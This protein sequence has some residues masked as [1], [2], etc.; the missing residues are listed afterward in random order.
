MRRLSLRTVAELGAITALALSC[1]SPASRG[2]QAPAS[3]AA[4]PVVERG[5][6]PRRGVFRRGQGAEVRLPA[7][8]DGVASL[9]G[10]GVALGFRLAGARPEGAVAEGDTLRYPGALGEGTELRMKPVDGGAEDVVQFERQPGDE[11]VDYLVDV[12]RVAGLRKVGQGVE[13]LD[14]GGAPRLRMEPPYIQGADGRVARAEVSL[15]CAHDTSPVAPWGRA[16]VRPGVDECR[17]TVSWAG[18][19]VS[20]PAALD[21][22]W[23]ATGS[24]AVGRAYHGFGELSGGRLLVAGGRSCANN[25]CSFP[26]VTEIYDP[27]TGTW[28]TTGDLNHE[29]DQTAGIAVPGFGVMIIGGDDSGP[30]TKIS[31]VYDEATGSWSDLPPMVAIRSEAMVTL[32]PDQKRV[33]VFGGLIPKD[34]TPV[35]DIEIFDPATKSWS[36]GGQ[37]AKGR[38]LGTVTRLPDDTYLIAGGT[39]CGNCGPVADAEIYDP[40]TSASTPVDSLAVAHFGHDAALLQIGGKPQVLVAGGSLEICEIFDPDTKKWTTT[41]P[42]FQGRVYSRSTVLSDG[43][44][45]V[46][47]GLI[48]PQ[49]EPAFVAERFDPKTLKWYPAGTNVDGH[50]VGS[51]L[52]MPGDRFLIAGGATENFLAKGNTT[53]VTEI[54]EPADL[55]QPCQGG[56]ECKSLRCA[57]GVCCDTACD[58]VCEAC[59][60]A[61]KGSGQDGVCGLVPSGDDPDNECPADDK[62]TCGKSG[63]CDGKG[64]CAFYAA[65]TPCGAATCTDGVSTGLLCTKDHKCQQQVATCL[66]FLCKDPTACATECDADDQCAENAHCQ[67]GLCE[68]DLPQGSPCDRALACQSGFCVDG[69]CC[70]SACDSSCQA[71]ASA[72]KQ[73]GGAD[74]AC[75]PAKAGSD[76]HDDCA[77]EPVLSCDKSG[78]C[79]GKG[80]CALYAAG[81]EC[82]PPTCAGDAKAGFRVGLSA[83]DGSGTCLAQPGASCGLFGCDQGKCK[84]G[85]AADGEC[86]AQAFCDKGLCAQRKAPGAACAE[87]RECLDGVCADGVCCNSPCTG[88]CEACNKDGV[89]VPVSGAPAKGHP[90]CPAT[91]PDRPCE[92]RLCDGVV[93]DS[94]AGFADKNVSCRKPSCA[95]GVAVQGAT[96]DGKGKCPEPALTRCEPFFC[97]GDACAQKC[98]SD[99]ECDPRF[100]CDTAK[101]DCTPRTTA[102][103]DGDHTLINPDG[104]KSD[105]APYTCEGSSCKAQ[106]KSVL[107]CVLPSVC[108]EATL[109]CVPPRPNPSDEA[110]CQAAPGPAPA[111]PL[112]AL[113]LASL[114]AARAARGR[115]ARGPRA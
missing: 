2:Q 61:K 106:C 14:E 101:G 27:A 41:T 60:A 88:P 34:N 77:D 102:A 83:C 113:A 52:V 35:P 72:L 22:V 42:M 31:E 90:A 45:L 1:L 108:D 80:Q 39:T 4:A 6:E 54:F 109:A 16:V 63:S 115:K 111:S 58:G 110:G 95:E 30:G 62:S 86:A 94:C 33:L 26:L 36:S 50:A 74:G 7:R 89:C 13:F 112:A 51:T 82:Q 53:K 103:C 48:V 24:M 64:A 38:Y 55:A 20:Y 67:G 47:G 23:T 57:D 73:D 66:P 32:M 98:A 49:F 65:N 114:L 28:A 59:T 9:R 18:R 25:S 71:C 91:S 44:L 29:H 70:N 97:S 107:D 75:G 46:V 79:D 76:P 17:V 21:P 10:Q 43:S 93:R 99:A 37:L 81:V 11:R 78:Q 104:S 105:C 19:G 84:T 85:C 56:G 15:G 8:A 12:R 40:A 100:Q 3:V 92:Q 96:C 87:S 69:V 5:P 68:L